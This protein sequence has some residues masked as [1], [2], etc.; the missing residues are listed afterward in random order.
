MIIDFHSHAFP[1]ALAPHAMASMMGGHIFPTGTD[2]S[3]TGLKAGMADAG[4]DL[5][6]VQPVCTNPLKLSKLN[7][8][9]I[10]RSGDTSDGLL[11]FGASHPAAPNWKEELKRLADNGVKGIKLHPGFQRAYMDDP[12]YLAIMESAAELGLIVLAH[13][14]PLL[15]RHPS[16]KFAPP[17]RVA[18]ALRAVK[19]SGLTF[20]AAHLGGCKS[21][22]EVM[23]HYGDLDCYFDLSEALTWPAD[24]NDPDFVLP[25]AKDLL[26]VIRTLGVERFLFACDVPWFF[27]KRVVAA[28]NA[29]PFTEAEREAIFGGN[30][31]RLLNL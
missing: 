6:V 28:A 10:A 24:P 22:D 15:H 29:F 18:K 1:D 3:I 2:G 12:A 31:K 26:R 23:E 7:D 4:I 9:S 5:T 20:V 14:N 30:A 11:Y 13:T 25:P 19:G 16:T 21:Y 17:W 27:Q 8:I